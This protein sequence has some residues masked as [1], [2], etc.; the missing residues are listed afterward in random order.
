M[1]NWYHIDFAKNLS[2]SESEKLVNEME[3]ER[4]AFLKD[5]LFTDLSDPHY[6]DVVINT[7]RF[8]I[9]E[10]AE[11]IIFLMKKKGLI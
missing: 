3:T 10:A 8:S 9:D 4:D 6:Y 5:Y 7:S 11:L 1:H 2:Q